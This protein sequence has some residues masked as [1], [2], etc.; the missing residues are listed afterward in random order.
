MVR[1]RVRVRTIR[2]RV[3]GIHVQSQNATA[4]DI[5]QANILFHCSALFSMPP[6]ILSDPGI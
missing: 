4:Q 5:I 2:V 6:S 3:R 1:V